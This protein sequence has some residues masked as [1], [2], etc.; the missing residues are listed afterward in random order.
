MQ[1][2]ILCNDYF[3]TLKVIRYRKTVIINNGCEK[4]W[5][6]TVVP[7]FKVISS[8]DSNDWQN[9]AKIKKE[10]IR[11]AAGLIRDSCDNLI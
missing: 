7:Y 1:I 4:T 8:F 2:S 6:K 5:K 3:I 10:Y 9:P 11:I